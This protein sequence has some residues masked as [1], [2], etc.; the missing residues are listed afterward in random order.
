MGQQD[1]GN[2]R[3]RDATLL[4]SND[5]AAPHI[6]N[7]LLDASFDESARAQAFRRWIRRACPEKDDAKQA[8]LRLCCNWDER[9]GGRHNDPHDN[10]F[11]HVSSGWV[12]ATPPWWTAILR[13]R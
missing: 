10:R 11:P 7:Q 8:V 9:Y 5:H 4:Q 13:R 1:P 2:R 6:E 12:D 3:I